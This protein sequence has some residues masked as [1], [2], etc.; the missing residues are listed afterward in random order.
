MTIIHTFE[1]EETKPIFF[2][3]NKKV[4]VVGAILLMSLTVLEI[5]AN[6]TLVNYGEKL[7]EISQ[8]QDQLQL[9]NQILENKIAVESSLS[10]IASS[11]SELGLASPKSIQY[12]H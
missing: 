2:G 7:E 9:E 10:H 8:M 12:L 1:I 6:N 5:W 4:V 3:W 11:S